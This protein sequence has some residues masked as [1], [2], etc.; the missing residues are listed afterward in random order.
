MIA[1]GRKSGSYTLI[2]PSTGNVL[3]RR[4]K[5]GAKVAKKKEE[6]TESEMT[7]APRSD[8]THEK[9]GGENWGQVNRMP[10]S[11]RRQVSEPMDTINSVK[12]A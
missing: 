1:G 4:E 7:A 3:L 5:P 2:C 12:S 9:F 10:F 8:K 6:E 11:N